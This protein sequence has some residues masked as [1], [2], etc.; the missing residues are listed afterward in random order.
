[1][2][3]EGTINVT[4]TLPQSLVEFLDSQA[5][6]MESNRSHAARLIFRKAMESTTK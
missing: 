3:K 6:A 5:K 4:L 2:T 1:M